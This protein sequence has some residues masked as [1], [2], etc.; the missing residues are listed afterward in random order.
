M[1]HP[2]GCKN[3]S[4]IELWDGTSLKYEVALSTKLRDISPIQTKSH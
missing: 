1:T 4:E 2:V 3:W